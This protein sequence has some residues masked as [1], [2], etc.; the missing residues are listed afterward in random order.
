M[1]EELL[2]ILE[3]PSASPTREQV[4]QWNREYPYCTL[5]AILFLK[6]NGTEG[7]EDMVKRMAILVPDRR[8]LAMQIDGIAKHFADFYPSEPE[9]ETP[10]TDATIDRFLASY[11]NTS[12]KEIDALSATIFN[13]MPDYAD[14]LAAQ[15]RG[16][17]QAKPQSE[18]DRLINEFIEK[19]QEREREA[20]VQAMT[21][22][23]NEEE[24]AE[25]AAADIGEPDDKDDSMLS[26]SLAKFYISQHKYSSALEIIENIN[27]K[28]PEK[29]IYFADQIR[30]LRKIIVNEQYINKKQ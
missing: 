6:Q 18:E 19:S 16:G 28:F 10:D 3:D 13:P 8:E 23:I 25:I 9:P 11:G 22:E 24:K 27:L 2:K 29:S 30:F 1:T 21:P 17:N 12:Q 26:E 20:S 15:E 5:P 14:V 7:N 4:E